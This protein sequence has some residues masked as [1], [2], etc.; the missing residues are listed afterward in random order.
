MS[1]IREEQVKQAYADW[2]D[3]RGMDVFMTLNTERTLAPLVSREKVVLESA[4]VKLSKMLIEMFGRA[5]TVAFGKTEN[6]VARRKLYKR[7]PKFRI[8]RAV[9]IHTDA[10]KTHAHI[11]VKTL[12]GWTQAEMISLLRE[13]WQCVNRAKVESE[14]HYKAEAVKNSIGNSFYI[15]SEETDKNKINENSIDMWSSYISKQ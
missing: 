4:E 2:F 8:H 1:K 10:N 12:D 6:G 3:S 15:T 14:Y 5:E 7:N 9:A 13:Q 11:R